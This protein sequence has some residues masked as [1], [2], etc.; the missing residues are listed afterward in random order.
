M[1]HWQAPAGG[2]LVA[3]LAGLLAADPHLLDVPC[4][5]KYGLV[6]VPATSMP[7]SCACNRSNDGLRVRVAAVRAGIES[8]EGRRWIVV[9]GD[10]ARRAFIWA[11][12]G[13]SDAI[14]AFRRS[15]F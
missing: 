14:I 13:S 7:D 4:A 15:S 2:T 8:K 6:H 5:C 9:T 10:S 1:Q 3:G 11:F 12:F